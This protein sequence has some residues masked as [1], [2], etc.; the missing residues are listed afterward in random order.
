MESTDKKTI[1]IKDIVCPMEINVHEKINQKIR[2]KEQLC[3]EIHEQRKDFK[4]TSVPL[5]IGCCGGGG[6][7]LFQNLNSYLMIQKL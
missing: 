5:V 7:K 3:S 2:T 6:E 1:I 4:G